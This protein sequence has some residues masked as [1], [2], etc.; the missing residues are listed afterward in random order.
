MRSSFRHPFLGSGR[1]SRESRGP[2]EAC[3][4]GWE[5]AADLSSGTL[6]GGSLRW[7]NLRSL[8]ILAG[9][10]GMLRALTPAHQA[11]GSHT[12]IEGTAA[13]V[14][15]LRTAQFPITR[16]YAYFDN[17]TFGPPPRACADAVARCLRDLSEGAQVPVSWAAEVDRV[18]GL[19]ARLYNC[20]TD[21]VAFMKSSAEAL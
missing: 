20:T 18:R 4:V 17:S 9:S 13:E 7:T 1:R 3:F 8:P 15:A 11:A 16:R 21:D 5:Y 6:Y 14:G 10:V 12:G 19:V 2:H